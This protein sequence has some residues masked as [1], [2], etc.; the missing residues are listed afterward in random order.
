MQNLKIG[1][2]VEKRSDLNPNGKLVVIKGDV[3]KTKT[4]NKNGTIKKYIKT[5]LLA[6]RLY[7]NHYICARFCTYL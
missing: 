5:N 2:K 7:K 3:K 4:V 1:D 6:R